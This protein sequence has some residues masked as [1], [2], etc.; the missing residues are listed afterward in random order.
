MTQPRIALV[1]TAHL[2]EGAVD[3][4]L[5]L[6]RDAVAAAGAEAAVVNWHDPD[7]D[8]S[9]FD[10]AL[11]RSTWDYTLR[12]GEF[13]AWADRCGAA[14]ALLNPPAVVRW[15]SDKRY[16]GEL[17]SLGVPAVA[18]R[19][20][21]PGGGVEGLPGDHEFVVKP[22]AG[23]G[24]RYAARY[25]PEQHE[26]A[27]A[28]V[29]RMHGEGI[30]AMVQPYMPRIDTTGERALV[31]VGGRFL[32]AISK[33]AV[34]SPDTRY[35]ARKVA[36]PGVRPWTPTGA[37][38]AAAE[39]ALSAVPG[40]PELLYARVDLVDAEDGTP[41]VMEL[42]LIEPQLFLTHHPDSLPLIADA[43]VRAAG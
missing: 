16:L 43:V 35:D 14:T 9:G 33:N 6:L 20:L 21:P 42:E 17:A 39:R 1:T 37:E 22:T 36:H 4:D 27:R 41:R 15:N 26:E 12:T 19:Y 7:V 8:W 5:P 31:F 24:A 30:T 13:L 38:L 34:L 28:H 32:H 23:A 18:T 3:H 29:E 40:R 10:L 2:P 25:R 11:I